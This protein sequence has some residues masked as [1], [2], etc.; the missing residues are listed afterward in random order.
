MSDREVHRQCFPPHQRRAT[1]VGSD[2][3]QFVCTVLKCGFARSEIY[4]EDVEERCA[5]YGQARQAAMAAASAACELA[6]MS[7]VVSECLGKQ[8]VAG[9][10]RTILLCTCCSKSGWVSSDWPSP[11]CRTIHTVR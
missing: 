6:R 1:A 10:V 4:N 5:D 7:E 2:N 3:L 9:P 8:I 11:D